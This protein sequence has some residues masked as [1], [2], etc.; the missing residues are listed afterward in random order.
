MMRADI[1]IFRGS[2]AEVIGSEA[3]HVRTDS[4]ARPVQNGM[5]EH[6]ESLDAP[7]KLVALCDREVLPEGS[8][9]IMNAAGPLK[10]PE[11]ALPRSSRP[12][13]TRIHRRHAVYQGSGS[14][15]RNWPD[16]ATPADLR[17]ALEYGFSQIGAEGA[18]P[19]V[20]RIA[21]GRT[22]IKLRAI[23]IAHTAIRSGNCQ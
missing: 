6:V 18:C 8:V 1:W 19:D 12:A 17:S 2:H 20:G 7:I 10:T 16:S 4:P 3:L 14:R 5:V 15:G 9:S 22:I 11:I 21:N 13:A 23:K